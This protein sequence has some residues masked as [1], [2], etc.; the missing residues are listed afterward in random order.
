MRSLASR[1]HPGSP[2]SRGAFRIL[3]GHGHEAVLELDPV[4]ATAHEA[5]IPEV[6]PAVCFERPDLHLVVRGDGAMPVQPELPAIGHDVGQLDVHDARPLPV[7]APPRGGM[8]APEVGR[9]ERAEVI[10]DRAVELAHQTGAGDAHL[11]ARL[12]EPGEVAQVQVIRP[13]V[14]IRINARRWR[15]RTPRRT[16]ATGHPHGSGRRRPRRPRRGSAECSPRR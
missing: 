8:Q 5:D 15:R 10:G 1:N 13:V 9:P 7:P 11:S 16:A 2:R 4:P 6:A 14:D 12:H 3:R